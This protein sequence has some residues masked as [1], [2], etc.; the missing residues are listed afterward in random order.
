LLFSMKSFIIFRTL[1]E[2]WCIY[3]Q[4]YICKCIRD[5]QDFPQYL[6]S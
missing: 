5:S 1:K 3:S 4:I 2:T 6:G